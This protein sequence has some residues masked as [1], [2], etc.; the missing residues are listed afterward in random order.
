MLSEIA[1]SFH[2]AI[3]LIKEYWDKIGNKLKNS[4][5]NEWS[6]PCLLVES[7]NNLDGHILLTLKAPDNLNKI[8]VTQSIFWLRLI[9]NRRLLNRM[10]PQ[11]RAK[12]LE[13][14]AKVNLYRLAD[15]TLMTNTRIPRIH[16]RSFFQKHSSFLNDNNNNQNHH[17]NND[18]EIKLKKLSFQLLATHQLKS[19]KHGW[20]KFDLTKSINNWFK[21]VKQQ[22][23]AGNLGKKLILLVDCPECNNIIGV[24]L[25]NGQ[26]QQQHSS[27]SNRSKSIIS[28]FTNHHFHNHNHNHFHN[29]QKSNDNNISTIKKSGKNGRKHRHYRPYLLLKTE[30]LVKSRQRRHSYNCEDVKKGTCCK[31]KLYVD[32]KDIGWSWI[33]YP[34]GFIANYCMGDCQYSHTN[35]LYAFPHS[36]VLDNYRVV[37]KNETISTCCSPSKLSPL[38]VVYYDNNKNP[39]KRDIENM[40]VD[41]CG[42]TF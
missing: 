6:W 39:I 40:I 5:N 21:S 32:F 3:T 27:G 13:K 1:K 36:H 31:Q 4:M 22:Q 29:N 24:D 26:Q 35:D 12:I 41:E 15:N 42:C 25:G 33:I 9:M 17:N 18:E 8:N 14:S 16:S 2:F 38:S 7:R 10:D 23:F 30:M 11:S 20:I 37:H 28:T 19:L 34:E